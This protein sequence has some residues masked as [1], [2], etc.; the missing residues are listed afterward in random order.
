MIDGTAV[1]PGRIRIMNTKNDPPA[2]E[3]GRGPM[4]REERERIGRIEFVKTGAAP[5]PAAGKTLL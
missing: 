1:A 4:E 3:G 2:A 5:R